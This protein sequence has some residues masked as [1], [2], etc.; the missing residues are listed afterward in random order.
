VHFSLVCTEAGN[1]LLET[2]DAGLITYRQVCT[3]R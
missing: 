2:K 1:C 3:F